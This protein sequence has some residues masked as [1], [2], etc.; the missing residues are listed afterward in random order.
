M[1]QGQPSPEAQT[2]GRPHRWPLLVMPENREEDTNKDSRLVNGY[3]EKEPQGDVWLYKRPGLKVFSRPSGGDG[4]GQGIYNWDGDVYSIFNGTLYKNNAFIGGTINTTNGVYR[5][6][7]V[8][9]NGDAAA[10]ADVPRLVFSNGLHCYEYSATYGFQDFTLNISGTSIAP[11]YAKGL[12]YLDGFL[13]VMQPATASIATSSTLVCSDDIRSPW[14]PLDKIIANIEPSRGVALAKQL[15]YIVVLKVASTEMFYDAGNPTA[16]PLGRVQGTKLSY[17]CANQDSVRELD[18]KLFWLSTNENGSIQILKLE[19]LRLQ[20]ISTPAIERLLGE[21]DITS[22]LSWTLKYEGHVWYAITVVA[23]NLTLVFDV[24][25]GLWAQWTG[26]DGNYLPIVSSTYNS[27]TSQVLLQHAT[28]GYL[29]VVDSAQTTDYGNAI[30]VDIYT[31]NYDAG[32]ARD[33]MLTTM[34]F[35][36]SQQA[37][38]TLQVR[39]S[40]DDYQSWSS[41]R[42]IDLGA[43][44]P[45]LD[46]NGTFKRRAINFRHQSPTR[47]RLK[48]VDLQ[49][50]IGTL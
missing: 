45:R 46:N 10:F 19:D 37:G 9:G 3:M 6:T 35:D 16:S 8:M 38:S 1:A 11:P 20:I 7:S 31:P 33:K 26:P 14:D 17:G 28:N 18:G 12:V 21:S 50:D 27:A 44:K 48:S 40:D 22:V 29:Y 23:A 47:F 13:C 43:K 15:I 5:F 25:T 34:Y 41:F 42:A 24:T 2:V 30:T 32:T 36:A 4:L 39:V 49:M